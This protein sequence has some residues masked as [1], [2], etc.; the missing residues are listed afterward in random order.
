[1]SWVIQPASPDIPSRARMEA[2]FPSVVFSSRSL[3]VAALFEPSPC[4]CA[5]ALEQC[6]AWFGSNV[7]TRRGG[8]HTCKLRRRDALGN[9]RIDRSFEAD[10]NERLARADVSPGVNGIRWT[11]FSQ[12]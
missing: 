9:A 11:R 7:S 2:V 10:D 6:A 5:T 4:P 8:W 1:M 12:I 3:T